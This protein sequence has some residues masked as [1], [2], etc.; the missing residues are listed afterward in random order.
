VTSS[1]LLD[2]LQAALGSTYRLE[3]ELG[4]GGMSRVFLAE[5]TALHRRV[6]IKVLPPDYAAVLSSERFRREIEVAAGLS[7]PH[8][9]PVL[10]GGEAGQSTGG[11]PEFLY[12]TMPFVDGESLRARLSKGAIPVGETVRILSEVADALGYA[13]R[14]GVIHRDIK[15]DNVLLSEGHAVV[16]DFGVAKAVATARTEGGGPGLTT[17]G[18]SIGTPLYMAPEQIAADPHLD[19]RADLYAFGVMGYE[20]LTGK[21]P[22]GDRPPQ[23]ILAAHLTEK[24]EDL[25]ARVP[26]CPSALAAVLMQCLEKE[27]ANR[28]ASADEIRQRLGPLASGAHAPVRR[29]RRGF[30]IAAVGS[31]AAA[32]LG[33]AYA[34]GLW[35]G[36]SL[37]AQGVLALRDP[38]LVGDITNHTRDSTLALAVG[39]ALRIDLTQSRTVTVLAPTQVSEA[40][41]R[42]QRP[43][44]TPLDLAL[45]R[46]VAQRAGAKVVVI[47]DIASVGPGFTVS[48]QILL[49]ETGE[50]LAAV[51]EVA[52]DSTEIIEAIGKVSHE[53]RRRIGESVRNIA[54][55]QPLEQV[56]TTSL[57]ALRKYSQALR[58]ARTE[59]SS[60]R[61]DQLLED[62]VGLDSGFAMAWRRL[63]VNYGNVGLRSKQRRALTQA[64]AHQDRLTERERYLTLGTYYS[65]T[66]LNPP[67]AI[68][69]YQSLVELEPDNMPALNNLGLVYARLKDYPKSVE[70]YRRAMA[71]DSGSGT[72]W[73]NEVEGLIML[74]DPAGAQLA[75]DVAAKR[76]PDYSGAPWMHA[77]LMVGRAQYDSARQV[78]E[79]IRRQPGV[80]A[81]DRQGATWQ[82]THLDL[83]EGRV[84]RVEGSIEEL[85]RLAA[86]GGEQSEAL[87]S[88]LGG[89]VIQAWFRGNRVAG[90]RALDAALRHYP[91]AQMDTLDRPYLDIAYTQILMGQIDRARATLHEFERLVPQESRARQEGFRLGVAGQ[92]A[93]LS[94]DTA[95]GIRQLKA[96]L[97]VDQ[98]EH[99]VYP[100][101]GRAFEA[102]GQPDSA[103]SAYEN[104]L[105]TPMEDPLEIDAYYLPWAHKRLGE[106][107]E[108]RGDREKAALHYGKFIELWKNADAELQPQVAEAR[109]RLAELVGEG[110]N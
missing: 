91:L 21:P 44:G 37:V 105:A 2:R 71:A 61:A 1:D 15:P 34:A 33:I 96:A 93:V 109:R 90:A 59:G 18:M 17:A 28:P 45:A 76:F 75:F 83:L 39:E 54:A 79:G 74:R 7:H 107:Y 110:K 49:A 48:A 56:S 58:I 62:A 42:M 97:A 50:P 64:V 108:Q 65:Q 35:P 63:G 26:E 10:A 12:Y 70:Y 19:H 106:L 92:I 51:R 4:G 89:A 31:A 27:A 94:G 8:V 82:L 25:A 22:F 52:K 103:I 40:L 30:W 77:E 38:I 69:A 100:D 32:V 81:R 41:A 20:M 36:R 60:E 47:G 5:E 104:Y 6:V 95:E 87:G 24:P 43:A 99:C 11:E 84:G 9:V 16:T 46:E 57:E 72:A 14:R 66:Q 3:K 88:E 29:P 78:Y 13:H 53:L 67:K 101:L 80:R 68:A 23:A 86:E 55:G 98:C 73:F 85:G 102:A